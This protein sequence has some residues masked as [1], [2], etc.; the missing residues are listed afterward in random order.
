MFEQLGE[1]LR[2]TVK[3]LKGQAR[4]SESNIESSLREIRMALL[5]ADVALPVAKEFVA[6]VKEKALGAEVVASLSPGQALVKIVHDELVRIMGEGEQS[7]NFSVPAPAAI[8]V[9]GLQGA[10]KTTSV[11]KN[12]KAIKGKTKKARNASEC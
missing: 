11:A 9:A 12:C 1:R 4:I 10:G 8:L 3:K 5:E 6:A 2:G 7:L